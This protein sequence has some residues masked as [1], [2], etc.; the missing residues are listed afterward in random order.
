[1]NCISP[2]VRRNKKIE[3]FYKNVFLSQHC[4]LIIKNLAVLN[5]KKLESQNKLTRHE[6]FP[7]TCIREET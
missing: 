7:G 3:L 1:M 5:Y 6:L 4:Y 2:V